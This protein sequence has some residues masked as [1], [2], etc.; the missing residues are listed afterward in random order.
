MKTTIIKRN[1][2]KWEELKIDKA[3]EKKS[4]EIRKMKK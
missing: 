2:E 3:D 4:A 1:G